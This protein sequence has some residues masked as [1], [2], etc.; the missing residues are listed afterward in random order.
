MRHIPRHVKI[1]LSKYK[2]QVL[3]S[4]QDKQII[5]YSDILEARR[6]WASICSVLKEHV[7]QDSYM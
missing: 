7:N 6:Q 1:K 3:E 2:E 4:A 5:T